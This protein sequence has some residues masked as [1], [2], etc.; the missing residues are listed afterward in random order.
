LSFQA[1]GVSQQIYQLSNPNK[2]KE[3]G[4][5]GKFVGRLSLCLRAE[6]LPFG[7]L[8]V[9]FNQRLAAKRAI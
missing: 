5:F 7:W 3:S 2:K 9:S 4:R 8:A 6:V 1:S